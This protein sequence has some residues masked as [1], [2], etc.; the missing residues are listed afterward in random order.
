MDT[1]DGVRVR[2]GEHEIEAAVLREDP[3]T[4]A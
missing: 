3:S 1:T 2:A 4:P